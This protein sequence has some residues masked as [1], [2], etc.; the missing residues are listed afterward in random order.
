MKDCKGV[1]KTHVYEFGRLS[2]P[3][4]VSFALWLS[5]WV[6]NWKSQLQWKSQRAKFKREPCYHI[7]S[8][9]CH[10]LLYCPLMYCEFDN[11]SCHTTGETL[12][13]GPA[14]KKLLFLLDICT[15]DFWTSSFLNWLPRHSKRRKFHNLDSSTILQ[16]SFQISLDFYVVV[17]KIDPKQTFF[18]KESA[19]NS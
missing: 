6:N 8:F 12:S 5:F 15:Y 17:G 4:R 10:H 16:H 19:K 3:C 13:S 1:Q 2:Y 14:F 7:W 9:C 11:A 18:T